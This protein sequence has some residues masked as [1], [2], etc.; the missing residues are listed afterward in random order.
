MGRLVQLCFLVV[1]AF[2]FAQLPQRLENCLP[3]PTFAQ[4]VRQMQEERRSK[5][6]PPKR[7]KIQ[8][9]VIKAEPALPQAPA[10]QI[11]AEVKSKMDDSEDSP[12]NSWLDEL[13]ERVRDGMQ[14][15]GY[16]K[17]VV[18]DPQMRVLREDLKTKTVTIT[19][20]VDT[21]ALYRLSEIQFGRN[22]IASFEQMRPLFLIREGE[23]FDTLKLGEGI[24]AL[25]YLY[26]ERGFI[27]FAAVP[28]FQVDESRSLITLVLDLDQ[29]KQFHVG[30]FRILGLEPAL[31]QELIAESGLAAGSIFNPRLLTKFFQSNRSVLPSDANADN[32]TEYKVNENDATVD[33]ILDFRTCS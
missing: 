16:F 22:T 15:H 19:L 3:Y 1:P 8:S 20:P 13:G 2:S 11:A 18:A 9:L 21:G 24:E 26:A 12:D 5:E 14:H 31:A 30:T 23:V 17:A 28:S 29:G 33:I 32:D 7:I 6:P 10:V 4:E 25:R 27:N